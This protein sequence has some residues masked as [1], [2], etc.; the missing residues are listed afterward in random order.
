VSE[1]RLAL[2]D[3]AATEALGAALARTL[4]TG[5]GSPLIVYLHGELGAGKT[6]LARGFLR[7]LGVAGTIR[8]PSYTLVESYGAL[9]GEIWHADLYRLAAPDEIGAL[10]LHELPGV[11]VLLVEWPERGLPGLAP[12]DLVVGLHHGGEART[13]GVAAGS[14]RGGRWLAALAETL[15]FT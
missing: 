2:P 15:P 13:A 11:A 14:E 3:A 7:A 12:A 9:P 10:G 5:V 1:V 8:S 4:P 6:T